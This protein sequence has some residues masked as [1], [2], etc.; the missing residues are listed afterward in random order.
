VDWGDGT[1][2]AFTY[3]AGTTSFRETHRYLDDNPSG[4]PADRYAVTLTLADDDTGR[5][6]DSAEVLVTNL[7]PEI[8]QVGNTASA[9]GVA[10]EGTLVTVSAAFTD[11]GTR[12]THVATIDWGDGTVTTAAVSEA[13]GSGTLTGSHAY[14]YGG[15]YTVTVTVTDDD[16]GEVTAVTTA[17]IT[18]AGV[19][20]DGTLYVVGTDAGD[21][22]DVDLDQESPHRTE[23]V[24]RAT[25]LPAVDGVPE[26]DQAVA[27][28]RRYLSFD[29]ALVDRIVVILGGGNDTLTIDQDV[30]LTAVID[31]GSGNDK[32]S[33]GGGSNLIWGGDGDD[34]LNGGVGRDLLIGGRGADK[35]LAYSGDDVLVSG[36][37]AY[38]PVAGP[39]S[40][41]FAD[42]LL[43]VLAEWNRTD[44]TYQQ[45]VANVQAG[46]GLTGGHA[47]DAA[48]VSGDAERDE[49][50]GSSGLDWFFVSLGADEY[51]SAGSGDEF[52]TALEG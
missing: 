38:D 22:V 51:D 1:V 18:G 27:F 26:P 35:I 13:G 46:G 32:L 2:E 36:A 34:E 20:L 10:G 7:G 31:G 24:V 37:T 45:R 41:A 43:Q 5:D 8:T 48:T 14:Q 49:L 15:L 44:L 40:E 28:G 3:A 52:V 6:E 12:D 33:G 47:L 50:H 16:T 4:T 9:F 30:R 42:A 25:F 17:V 21:W 39:T 11:R 19:S 23:I 29:P